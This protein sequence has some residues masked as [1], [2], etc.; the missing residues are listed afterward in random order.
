VAEKER[1][2]NK[3]RREQAREQRK[4]E[5]AERARQQKRAKAKGGLITAAIVAVVGLVLFQAV[6]GGPE[7]IDGGIELA[8]ADVTDAQEAAG[9]EM[10]AER[11]PLEE[12]YHF[13]GDAAPPADSIYTD[14]RPTHSGPHNELV[15]PVSEDG[16]SSQIE[17]RSSTHNLEH[18]SVIAWY[19]PEQ[20]DDA[21]VI[22]DWNAQLNASGFQMQQGSG[23]GIMSAPYE[24]PGIESGKA[25]AFRAWGTAMDC[26]T[27]DEDVANGFVAQHFGSR[28]IGPER[29]LAPYPDGVVEVTDLDLDDT[30]TEEAPLDGEEPPTLD[31]EDV[32]DETG[33]TEELDDDDAVD[34]DAPEDAEEAP[35]DE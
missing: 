16:F 5:E 29:F 8:A 19:D 31:E 27:F 22:R 6:T 13:T 10:L 30:T 28:G 20:I 25:V 32:E 9:C 15:S 24:D 26:D 14:T 4:R 35:E 7:T 17:E 23:A 11:E 34:P 2:T 33:G 12:R 18:G 21:S 3:E 1:L